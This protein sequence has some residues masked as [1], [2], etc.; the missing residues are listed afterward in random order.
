MIRFPFII[1]F[2]FILRLFLVNF[3]SEHGVIIEDAISVPAYKRQYISKDGS[4]IWEEQTLQLMTS[5][6]N[7]YNQ[8]R[9]ALPDRLYHNRKKLTRLKQDNDYVIAE[10]EDG[11]IEKC[12]LLVGA[13]G[14]SSTV[15]KQ[16]LPEVTIMLK[17]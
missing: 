10:F 2:P 17:E 16:L 7:I 8:L 4:I 11:Q 12:D 1:L 5:W 13:D 15:R 6:D 14:S 9:N 3:L